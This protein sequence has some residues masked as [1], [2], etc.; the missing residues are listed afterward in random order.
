MRSIFDQIYR[1][2]LQRIGKREVSAIL[3]VMGLAAGAIVVITQHSDRERECAVMARDKMIEWQ[4]GKHITELNRSLDQ[5]RTMQ[6]D[7]AR[8]CLDAS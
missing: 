8:E 2:Q 7:Y 5:L 3:L 1:E 4:E 6:E